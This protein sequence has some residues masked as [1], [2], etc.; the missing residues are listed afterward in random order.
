VGNDLHEVLTEVRELILDAGSLVKATAGGKRRGSSPAWVRVELRPVRIKAGDRLQIITFDER[1]SHT[2]NEPWGED[3]A[4]ALDALLAEPFSHWHVSTSK[5]ELGFR[6]T[7]S[8]KV[9]VTRNSQG[10]EQQ[11]E[12]DRAKH[13][14]VDPTDPFLRELGVTTAEGRVKA[15]RSDKYHQVE[16]FVRL[17]DAA[18]REGLAAGRLDRRPLRVVDLGCGNAYLTFAAY[19]HLTDGLG[20]DVELVG[21]DV[22]AQAREHNEAVAARL[23]WSQHVTFVEGSIASAAVS[24]PVDVVLALHACDT[25]TDDA[26]A[27]AIEWE[28]PL[29]LAAPCCHNDIQR[30]LRQ[31]E[32][33]VPFGMVTRNGLLRERLGDVLTD[34]LRAQILRLNGYRTDVVE[35]VD[36]RHTPR[37][38]LL[39]AHR[40]GAPATPE[41][42]AEYDTLVRQWHLEPRLA[43]LLLSQERRVHPI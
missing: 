1:Q 11:T 43:H 38:A 9:L 3:A 26:L 40:T 4:K 35:F 21:V 7:K 22:K 19:R 37:N 12:H 20:L 24:T 8:D 16:E 10:R 32:T 41:H 25:A 13:R 14:L 17:L 5:G 30:Q 28:A 6:V 39:R 29:V 15:G 33:P 34:A 31:Q 23:G 18:V 27:R 42:V 36:S 2:R